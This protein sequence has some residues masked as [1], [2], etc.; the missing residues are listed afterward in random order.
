MRR[1]ADLDYVVRNPI[2]SAINIV[3]NN[4]QNSKLGLLFY[5]TGL[6]LSFCCYLKFKRKQKKITTLYDKIK[7][8]SPLN[9]DLLILIDESWR[10]GKYDNFTYLLP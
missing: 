8:Q 5:A 9:K 3:L 4:K 1:N 10:D 7:L 6:F 2:I